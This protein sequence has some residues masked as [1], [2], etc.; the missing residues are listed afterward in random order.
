MS[1]TFRNRNYNVWEIVQLHYIRFNDI[2]ERTSIIKSLI[3]EM[4]QSGKIK[5]AHPY[6][7]YTLSVTGQ[8]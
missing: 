8:D 7:S 3:M 6:H 4:I 5:G 1:Q 2:E